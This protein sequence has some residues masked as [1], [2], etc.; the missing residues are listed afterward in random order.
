[1]SP[2]AATTALSGG[3]AYSEMEPSPPAGA[4]PEVSEVAIFRALG[5]CWL[6]ALLLGL[7]ASAA[8]GSATWYLWPARFTAQALV[9]VPP[10]P[11]TYGEDL[12]QHIRT[13]S[14]LLKGRK[15]IEGALR[16]EEVVRLS[17]VRDEV[18]PAALIE[19]NLQID[20]NLGPEIL[21]VSLS[22]DR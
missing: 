3:G 11:G 2:L 22:G 13:Q 5:R 9:H 8:A 16:S 19:K 4:P 17:T 14:A 21:R 6:P 20:T 10:R 1:H 7:L 15:V 18:D 12:Q